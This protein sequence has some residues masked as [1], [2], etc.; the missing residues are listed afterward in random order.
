MLVELDRVCTSIEVHTLG[1]LRRYKE[2]M[3]LNNRKINKS[4]LARQL[5]IDRRTVGKYLDGYEKPKHRSKKSKYDSFIPTIDYLLSSKTQ[6]FVYRRNLY[7]YLQDNYGLTGSESTFRHFL[8]IHSDYED[9]FNKG[10]ISN[11]SCLAVM[12]FESAPGEQAQLDWKESI[13]FVLKD[14]DEVVKVNVFALI[15]GYSRFR[16]Y[17]LTLTKERDVL[18]DCLTRAFEAFGGVPETLLVDNMK[19]IMDDPRR[20]YSKGVVNEELEEYAKDFNFK[21]MPCIAATPQTKGKVENQMKVLEEIR[22]YSGT[23]T[24]VELVA[25]LTKINNKRNMM[26]HEGT[27]RIPIQ[28]FEKEKGSLQPL[29]NEQIRNQY[30]IETRTVKVNSASMITVKTNQYSVPPKYVGKHVQYQILA[31]RLYVYSSMNLIAFHNISDKKLNY[32]ESHYFEIASKHFKGKDKEEI[33]KFAKANLEK[34]GGIY[35]AN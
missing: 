21:I 11:S 3:D 31:S 29:P 26:I 16:V 35:N 10:K 19:T 27:G 28:D 25:L 2:F 1:D 30:K 7:T 14:T 6:T 17:R 33:E 18:L 22:A 24:Y 32:E 9:Y 4:K 12:R 13:E 23:L 15:L 20:T 34:I 5:N 8:K